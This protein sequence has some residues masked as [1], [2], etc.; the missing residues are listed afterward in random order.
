MHKKVAKQKRAFSS[1]TFNRQY[2]FSRMERSGAFLTTAESIVFQ[3][4]KDAKHPKFKE[5]QKIIKN[6]SP[7]TGLSKL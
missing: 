1:Y 2:A 4:C 3:L 6:P 5:I 7:N